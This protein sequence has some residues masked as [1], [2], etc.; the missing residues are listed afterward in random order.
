M[1]PTPNDQATHYAALSTE[2]LA[3]CNGGRR[4]RLIEVL[5]RLFA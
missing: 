2:E 5:H 1:I 4:N 3:E